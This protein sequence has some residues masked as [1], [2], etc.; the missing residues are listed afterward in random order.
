MIKFL[1]F[2]LR[3][4]KAGQGA[5]CWLKI[6]LIYLNEEL[7]LVLYT[8]PLL[9][10]SL[11]AAAVITLILFLRAYFLLGTLLA[12]FLIQEDTSCAHTSK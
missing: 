5:L 6:Q 8:P 1:L 2:K 4:R 12:Y 10:L 3:T 7:E 9:C 11:L